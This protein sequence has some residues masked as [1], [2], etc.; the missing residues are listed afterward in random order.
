MIKKFNAENLNLL[1]KLSQKCRLC[2]NI[3][4]I[5]RKKNEIGFCQTGSK[6]P[7]HHIGL[8]F[9]EEPP[10]SGTKGSGA[11]FFAF[12]NLRCI[13]CQNY[14]IS[15]KPE[16]RKITWYLPETL[17]GEMLKL[18]ELGAHNINLVSPTHINTYL[19]KAIFEAK[20]QGLR[21]PVVYNCNGY[22]LAT[23]LKYLEGLVDIYLPDFKYGSDKLAEKYSSVKNYFIV[24]KNALSEMYRQVGNLE[25]NENGLAR[26]GL[27]VRHLILPN[28]QS[29]SRKVLTFLST[30]SK[31]LNISLMSQY[32]PLYLAKTEPLINRTLLEKEYKAIINFAIKLEL[33]NCFIQEFSSQK[34]FIPDFNESTPFKNN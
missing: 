32:S 16:E 18:Q 20:K 15:Q 8:H 27:L 11:I 7:V 34:A 33:E 26:K 22:E 19:A 9:G 3:C 25:L 4:N 14:Q 13:F 31:S 21:I 6:I 2:P 5:N 23:T 28:N 29:S 30:L 1:D 10:I 17:A 12:C 24:A